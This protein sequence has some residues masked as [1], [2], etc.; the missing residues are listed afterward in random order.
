VCPKCESKDIDTYDRF[1][2]GLSI[3]LLS[4][5]AFVVF[6]VFGGHPAINVGL[7]ALMLIVGV[8][9]LILTAASGRRINTCKTCRYQ[10]K[11]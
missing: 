5:V 8:I 11:G 3:L 1:T 6:S 2:G 4:P 10:W 7:F 9:G